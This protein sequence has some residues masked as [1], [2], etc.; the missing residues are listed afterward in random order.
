MLPACARVYIKDLILNYSIQISLIFNIIQTTLKI[1][2]YTYKPKLRALY[3][4]TA[5]QNFE[6]V[7]SCI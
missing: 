5:P 2:Y 1:L 4:Y 3:I 7:Y 6:G